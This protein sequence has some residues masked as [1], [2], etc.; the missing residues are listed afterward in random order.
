MAGGKGESPWAERFVSINRIDRTEPNRA[1]RTGQL[2]LDDVREA[3]GLF[4]VVN[5]WPPGGG[6]M[7]EL[8]MAIAWRKPVLPLPGDFRRWTWRGLSARPV[9]VHRP[10]ADRPGGRLV[11]LDRRAAR[12]G[13]GA[14][15]LAGGRVGGR[16]APSGPPGRG[17][18]G[19]GRVE[20]CL[21]REVEPERVSDP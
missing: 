5:G 6:M 7:A 4:A 18:T 9:G 16:T 11:R 17:R 15:P 3:N 2:R 8:G 20:P 10:P 1:N 12:S 21:G 14:R 13:P 19:C